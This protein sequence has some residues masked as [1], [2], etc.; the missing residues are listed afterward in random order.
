MDTN[1]KES[2]GN[3]H[4]NLDSDLNIVVSV[5]DTFSFSTPIL[6]IPFESHDKFID[7]I[8]KAASAAKYARVLDSLP[9]ALPLSIRHLPR[10]ALAELIEDAE[11]DTSAASAKWGY[12][13]EFLNEVLQKFRGLL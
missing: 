10:S 13:V 7:I 6:S 1:F 4:F 11:L 9:E 2:F 12:S 5:G 8:T 3:L